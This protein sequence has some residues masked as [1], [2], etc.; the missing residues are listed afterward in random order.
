MFLM[1]QAAAPFVSLLGDPH[2]Y[3]N[4]S[5]ETFYAWATT[6]GFTP[7]KDNLAYI[8]PGMVRTA[9][10]SFLGWWARAHSHI[11][12]VA[13][14]VAPPAKRDQLPLWHSLYI[15]IEFNCFHYG[16]KMIRQGVLTWGQLQ[17]LE[18]VRPLNALPGTCKGVY[19]L[20]RRLLNKVPSQRGF[21]T[22]AVRAQHWTRAWLL[23]F[24]ASQ[25]GVRDS[26]TPEVR[27]QW[28]QAQLPPRVRD[29]ATKSA[30]AQTDCACES[31]QEVWHG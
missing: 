13:P 12:R 26:Q 22:P 31:L 16:I 10:L 23:Q 17:S 1:H 19:N 2:K 11:Q 24:Y 6:I 30:V 27:E 29:F 28:A 4:K 18:D 20:G 9:E 25:P 5:V 8:Q 15:R 21:D 7:S 14:Q 3:P